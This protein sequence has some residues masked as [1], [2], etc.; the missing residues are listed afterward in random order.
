MS[1][2]VMLDTTPLGKLVNPNADREIADW[3]ARLAQAKIR[4]I[5][6]EI[7]DYEL[8]REL[9]R[10]RSVRALQRLEQLEAV[11]SYA[12]ITTGVMRQAARWWAQARNRG[13]P[14]ADPKELDGD[15]IL[16]AQA[17]EAGAIVATENVGHLSFFVEAKHWW[18]VGPLRGS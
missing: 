16:A 17:L 11:H 14:T 10:I 6:P 1:R 18:E 4:I 2:P 12:P 8:R 5:I 7:A 13:R 3:Y 9:L 15:V